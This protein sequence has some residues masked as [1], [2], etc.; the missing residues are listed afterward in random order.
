MGD[1]RVRRS[2][3]AIGALFLVSA[4]MRI[5]LSVLPPLLPRIEADLVLSHAVGGLLTSASFVMMGF[6][7]LAT[8]AA[9]R[10]FGIVRGVTVATGITLLCGIARWAAPDALSVIL[11]GI[12]LGLAIGLAMGLMPLVVREQFIGRIGVGTSVYVTGISVGSWLASA[13]AALIAQALAGWRPT[14]LVFAALGLLLMSPWVAAVRDV[15]T[16]TP[17]RARITPKL[18]SSPVALLSIA[19]FAFQAMLFFGLNTWLPAA[20]VERGWSE[21]D[22]GLLG[23]ALTATGL[24]GSLMVAMVPD[25]ARSTD[26][27]LV[28]AA[29]ATGI[30]CFGFVVLPEGAWIW[31]SVAGIAIGVLFVLSL[32]LPVELGGNAQE[33]ASLSALTLAFGYW[34]GGLAPGLLGLIRDSSGAFTMSFAVLGALALMLMFVSI[35]FSRARRDTDRRYAG[36][37]IPAEQKPR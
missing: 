33:V 35:A 6:G 8:G 17:A 37:E 20:H 30:G 10:S 21:I 19:I 28:M 14:L 27:Y 23:S 29:L 26:R 18:P 31:T 3:N 24:L 15:Q 7:A 16:G 2:A 34:T 13:S 22:A 12:P 32:K 5:Q 4:A 36:V 9:L 11:V 25:G 1:A